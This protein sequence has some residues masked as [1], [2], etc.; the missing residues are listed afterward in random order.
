M[1]L[2]K[3]QQPYTVGRHIYTV[4]QAIKASNAGAQYEKFAKL[5]G[6]ICSY[7]VTWKAY[8]SNVFEIIHKKVS[9]GD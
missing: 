7:T 4:T 8:Y 5:L 2:I 3:S 1:L 9:T 6:A